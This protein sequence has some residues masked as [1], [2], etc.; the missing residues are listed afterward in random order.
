MAGGAAA[1]ECAC[2]RSGERAQGDAG[3]DRESGWLSIA[4]V[5]G[6]LPSEEWSSELRNLL[7]D[8]GWRSQGATS[9]DLFAVRNPT[10]DVLEVLSGKS[11]RGRL[12]GVDTGVAATARSVALG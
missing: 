2:A 12:S 8:L 7:V 10:L 9:L 3:A 4:L 5:A 11:R 6:G 1:G